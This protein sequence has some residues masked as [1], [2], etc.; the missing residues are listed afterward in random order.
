M[1]LS[2]AYGEKDKIIA[3]QELRRQPMAKTDNTTRPRPRLQNF[4]DPG[5]SQH[6]CRGVAAGGDHQGPLDLRYERGPLQCRPRV[7]VEYLRQR[8]LNGVES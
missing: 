2:R 4:I 5:R 1:K 7:C 8:G 6:G 3:A